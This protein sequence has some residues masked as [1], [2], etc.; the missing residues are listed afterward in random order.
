VGEGVKG[1][2]GGIVKLLHQPLKEQLRAQK[3]MKK[4]Q[5]KKRE[6]RRKENGERRRKE[7]DMREKG[8]FDCEDLSNSYAKFPGRATGGRSSQEKPPIRAYM[9]NFRIRRANVL[10]A[11]PGNL[12]ELRTAIMNSE[13]CKAEWRRRRNGEW[14]EG[15]GALDDR[16]KGKKVVRE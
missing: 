4:R 5:K 16:E 15:W 11:F 2:E 3:K 10:P 9:V 8:P 13:C 6:R 1:R 14:S 7:K 12:I